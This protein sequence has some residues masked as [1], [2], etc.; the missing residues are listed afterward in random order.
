MQFGVHGQAV[1]K[2]KAFPLPVAAA[3]LLEI[4][5]DA[6]GQLPD[7]RVSL[8]A[9]PGAGQLAA[10]AARAVGHDGSRVRFQ[11]AS[12]F[13][14]ITELMQRQRFRRW[15]TAPG[16]SRR[17]CAHPA[18]AVG[19]PRPAIGITVAVAGECPTGGG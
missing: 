4:V 18:V 2:D 10:D 19:D 7:F 13:L 5:Q 16:V 12:R 8:L 11:V 9:Q 6:S 15:Q 17:H 14:E 3:A 1:V